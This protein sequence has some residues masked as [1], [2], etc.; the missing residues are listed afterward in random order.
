M[1]F[2]RFIPE[3]NLK[4]SLKNQSSKNDK[5]RPGPGLQETR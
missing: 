4:L 5:T 3:K 1:T 2:P